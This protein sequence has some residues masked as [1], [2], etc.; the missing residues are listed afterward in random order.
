MSNIAVFNPG[1]NLPSFVKKGVLSAVAQ[2][3]A[4]GGATGKRVSIKGG[5]FRLYS[6]GK[7]VTSIEERFLDVVIVNAAPKVHRTFYA[8]KFDED[9]VSSPDCWS[10]DGDKPDASVK[11]PVSATCATC[12]NNIKGS[13]E[14]E[15]RACRYGQKLAVVLANDVEGDVLQLSLP[16][17]SIFGK[18]EGDNRPLQEYARYLV[19][20]GIDPSML[21]TRLRFDTTAAVPKLFFKPM[22]WLTEDEYA[23]TQ[24]KGQSHDAIQAITFTVSQ[25]D[26]VAPVSAEGPRQAAAAKAAAKPAPAPEPEPEAEPPAPPPK[27]KAKPA[28]AKPA[29]APETEEEPPAPEPKKRVAAAPPAPVESTGLAA[30]LGQWD[31]E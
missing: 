5:V 3:L 31:D 6:N 2:A 30:V 4:G 22:R 23:I 28:A 29:P 11:A 24:E 7:E 27:A 20:Q 9:T 15:S 8:K 10:A 21:V 25:Q 17:M 13:G 19:A 14:G 12:P 1:A 26:G 16:A 18:A